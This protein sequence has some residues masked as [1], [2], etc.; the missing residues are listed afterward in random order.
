MST[1]DNKLVWDW[2]LSHSEDGVFTSK[3]IDGKIGITVDCTFFKDNEVKV[4]VDKDKIDIHCL[5]E[6]VEKSGLVCK[7]EISRTYR[8]PQDLDPK[9]VKHSL[10]NGELTIT[11]EKKA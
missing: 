1:S 9:T 11:V 5:H 4:I 3:E 10:K 8:L 2:P 6:E 7:R